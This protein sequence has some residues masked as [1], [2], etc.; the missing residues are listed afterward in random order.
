MN[1]TAIVIAAVL[2]AVML[3]GCDANPD[4]EA[5]PTGILEEGT[6]PGF[7]TYKISAEKVTSNGVDIYM[8]GVTVSSSDR[9]TGYGIVLT[10]T[11]GLRNCVLLARDEEKKIL[12]DNIT[13]YTD[14]KAVIQSYLYGSVAWNGELYEYSGEFTCRTASKKQL[15]SARILSVVLSKNN[16]AAAEFKLPLGLKK[17]IKYVI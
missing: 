10:D 6:M 9:S 8:L 13:I 16:T 3:T 7:G 15:Q 5:A 12:Y 1:K 17:Y 4:E 11:D 14:D 2:A